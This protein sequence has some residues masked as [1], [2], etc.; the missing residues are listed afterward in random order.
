M[1]WIKADFHNEE[2]ILRRVSNSS[3]PIGNER[4]NQLTS[5]AVQNLVA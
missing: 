4:S 2:L 3:G 1:K 5:V